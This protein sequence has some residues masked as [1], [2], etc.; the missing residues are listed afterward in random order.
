VGLTK[1]STFE[2]YLLL[3]DACS[4]YTCIHGLQDKQ[5]A[6]VTDALTRYRANHGHI[7]NYGYLDIAG[8]RADSG[9]QFTSQAFKDHCWQSGINLTFA[10]PKKQYQNHQAESSWQTTTNM[11]MSLIVHARLPDFFMYHSLLYSCQIFN[12]LPVNGLYA[13]GHVSTPFELF[14]GEKPKIS[15]YFGVYTLLDK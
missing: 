1:D 6:C 8:I 11:A 10:A 15:H 4:C 14:E 9:S 2:F 7:G 5:T 13:Q 3:V 12:V